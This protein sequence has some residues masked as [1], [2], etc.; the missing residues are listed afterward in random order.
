[1]KLKVLNE[2][3][4]PLLRRKDLNIEVEHLST[5]TPNRSSIQKQ[6]S[7]K[8]GVDEKKVYIIGIITLTGTNKS[9]C[10]VECYDDVATGDL[11]VPVY[12]RERGK[13]TGEK[14]KEKKRKEVKEPKEVKEAPKPS[15]VKEAPKPSEVKKEVKEPKEAPEP[16]EA[17]V[18]DEVKEK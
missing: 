4:N 9:I 10:K 7:S 3:Y 1:M 13:K 11:V 2:S 14:P 8:L 16:S 15:E 5:G 17:R 6:L 18:L 12:I